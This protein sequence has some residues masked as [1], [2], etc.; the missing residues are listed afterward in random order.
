MKNSTLFITVF[1]AVLLLAFQPFSTKAQETEYFYNRFGTPIFINKIENIIHIGLHHSTLP[2][3]R[4]KLIAQLSSMANYCVLPDGS[5]RF[6][7]KNDDISDFMLIALAN[8]N[9][10]FLQHEYKDP[11]G[12]VLWGSNRIII[13]LKD[14]YSICTVLD[15]LNIPVVQVEPKWYD[16][17]IFALTIPCDSNLFTIANRAY[18]CGMVEFSQP[19]LFHFS[20]LDGYDDNPIFEGQWNLSDITQEDAWDTTLTYLGINAIRAWD[21]STGYSNTHI[22]I[23]DN[24]VNSSH[25]DLNENFL[26]E[27]NYTGIAPSDMINARAHGTKCAGVIS[28]SNN[29]FGIIGVAHNCKFSSY[30]THCRIHINGRDLLEPPHDVDIDYFNDELVAEAIYHACDSTQTDIFSCSWH[31]DYIVSEVLQSAI[32]HATEY[33]RKGK[34]CVF[35]FSSGNRNNENETSDIRPTAVLSNV[36]SVGATSMTGYR[37]STGPPEGEVIHNWESCYGDSLDLMA[38]GEE[39]MT[40]CTSS[41]SCYST[42]EGTSAAAPQVAGVAA[43]VL[44]VDSSLTYR[45]VFEILCSTTTKVHPQYYRYAQRSEY[46]YGTWNEEVGYGLV[47]AHHAVLKTL[48]RDYYVS[49]NDSISLCDAVSFVAHG[50][51]PFNDSITC[52]WSAS[53]NIEILSCNDTIVTVRGITPGDGWIAF[54]IIHAGDSLPLYFPISIGCSDWSLI[55][56]EISTNTSISNASLVVSDLVID[57]LATLTITDTLYIAGGSRIIVRPGGKLVVNGGTLTS[58]CEGEMW[59]GIIVEG[60]NNIRQAALAQ[61]SVILNNATIENA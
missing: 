34:G 33:G 48:Y 35:V 49:G 59:Q 53:E 38:P 17:T 30:I 9:I 31:R 11:F 20:T 55:N 6:S 60:H 36:L 54:N 27:A 43:L 10:E 14:D 44:A 46:P 3:E 7:L 40:S 32:D 5:Y 15:T 19:A 26:F 12:D 16:S 2:I 29:S 18:D 42:F 45:Q 24:G 51:R 58:A 50:S 41:N 21:L 23:L 52:G 28:A 4:T 37:I 22:A 47:N 25:E 61:G 56:N 8:N 1:V 57:S 39:I 13:K